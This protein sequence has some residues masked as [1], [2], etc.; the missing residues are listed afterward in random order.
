MFA[1]GAEGSGGPLPR[2]G[3][4]RFLLERFP[5]T[6]QFIKFCMVGATGLLVDTAVFA[7]GT[8]FFRLDPRFAAIPAFAVAVTWTY[9]MNRIW[10]FRA[11][12]TGAVPVSYFTFVSV[13]FF[14]L[15]LRLAVMH[16]LMEYAGLGEFPLYYI[17]NLA[18][19]LVATVSN[20]LGSKY[21]AFRKS[22]V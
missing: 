18:G 3:P 5:W 6:R 7:I 20:F 14:G 12:G 11:Q 2:F 22:R 4:L 9:T 21:I 10:T 15:C 1:D 17:A 13:C 16:L 19:I 8:E